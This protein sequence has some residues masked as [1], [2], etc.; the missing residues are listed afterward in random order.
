M[1]DSALDDI[2]ID[3]AAD[4]AAEDEAFES[5]AL[6]FR[7]DEEKPGFW[8]TVGDVFVQGGRGA[9]KAF[10]WPADVLKIGMI[11]EGLSDLDEIEEAFRKEGKPFDREAYVKGVFETAQY[12][13]TQELAE[14]G[15]E[16]VTG[17]SL[18]PKTE[19]GKRAGQFATLATLSPGSL[20]RKATTGTIGA[21]T[22]A[23]LKGV[24][25]G[26]TKAELIGDVASLSSGAVGKGARQLS[27]GAQKLERTA[28]KHALPFL[29]FMAREREPLIK[30]RLFKATE[31]NLKESFNLSPKEALNRIV[32]DELPM[33]RLRNRGVDLD[34][35]G[36]H[37]YEVTRKLA[38]KNPKQLST[39]PMVKNID[40]EIERIQSLAPSPSDAQRAAIQI[41]ENQRDILK[42]SKPT[43][44]QLIDQHMNYNADMKQI[45]RK[46]EFSG[47]E[48]Q[49]RKAYE[50]LKNESI[51][52]M[53]T[54]D[55]KDTA[56]AFEAANKIYHEVKKLEQTE[57]LLAKIFDGET[58][59]H[60][61]LDK[62]LH[63]KQGNFLKRNMSK[64]AIEDLGDIAKYG[65]EAQEK[66]ASFIDL[67]SPAVL[68]E[69]K[70]WGQLAPF[71]FLP[72][73]LKGG[74]LGVASL[75]AKNIQGKLL[76]RDATREIYK[77]TLKH[78]AESSFN[79][80]KKDFDR[81]EREVRKEWGSVDNFVDDMLDEL[82]FFEED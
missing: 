81:L 61:K 10:T 4:E 1:A 12:I 70:S 23:A 63:S 17:L 76:T 71:L 30:G 36:E 80:L 69:V 43:A 45:Y 51:E 5:R 6:D 34:A 19:L 58:Y 31:K 53:K 3:L 64:Q 66:I 15:F 2:G 67:R 62:L 25:V 79:L 27:Q 41:L 11:G 50:F 29:E 49:V 73:S 78:A 24:G 14:Q 44:E 38:Q 59:N 8:D 72:H 57:S 35:L 52:L 16:K 33:A 21:G 54:Q 22:T 48:E 75:V 13:P 46:P 39:I 68:N 56:H 20:A 65:K 47:R 55:H 18:Q 26:E 37:A 74:L 9:L 7:D 32:K 82:R 60:K 40:A 77:L 28:K 42:V